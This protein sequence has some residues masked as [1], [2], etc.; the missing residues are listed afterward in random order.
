[1]RRFTTWAMALAA[2]ALLASPAWAQR[3]GG[4]GGFGGQSAVSLLATQESVQKEIKATEAD[5]KKAQDV[6]A[7]AR[8]ALQGLQGPERQAKQAEL[9]KELYAALKPDQAKRL[10][11]VVLQLQRVQAFSDAEVVKALSITPE[12]TTKIQ[13]IAQAQQAQMQEIFQG[14]RDNPQGA[15]QKMQELQKETFTKAAAVLTPDQQKKWKELVG[16]EFKGQIQQRG[17]RG[18]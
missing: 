8:D 10:R 14:A 2:V 5:I 15:Q 17:R 4:R 3:Q 12:Q 7:K 16:E 13:G 6:Q 18:A 1:M 9:D 11:Q